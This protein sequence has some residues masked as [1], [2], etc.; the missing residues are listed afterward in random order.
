M[1]ESSAGSFLLITVVGRTA[2]DAGR[3]S[4]AVSHSNLRWERQTEA[5]SC[6]FAADTRGWAGDEQLSVGSAGDVGHDSTCVSPPRPPPS[7]RLDAGVEAQDMTNKLQL[8]KGAQESEECL[9]SSECGDNGWP[10]NWEKQSWQRCGEACGRVNARANWALLP[11]AILLRLHW[12]SFST[13][14][15]PVTYSRSCATQS[16]H[17][18]KTL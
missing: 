16:S 11:D 5:G 10:R 17:I 3:V 13:I 15:C 4:C 8:R 1:L 14:N 6:I 18:Q 7:L 12:L 2:A 9:S